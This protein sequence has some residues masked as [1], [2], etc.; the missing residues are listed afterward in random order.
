[1]TT[2]YY[3]R[4]FLSINNLANGNAVVALVSIFGVF[5]ASANKHIFVATAR[6]QRKAHHMKSLDLKVLAL[7][8]FLKN[9]LRIRGCVYLCPSA[10]TTD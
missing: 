4:P 6:A 5:F 2:E 7:L 1:M 9:T 8:N 10:K 3:Q